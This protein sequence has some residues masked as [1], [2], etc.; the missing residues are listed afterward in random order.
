MKVFLRLAAV[1]TALL[2][3]G[4]SIYLDDHWNYSTQLT[5]ASFDDFIQSNLAQQKTVFVRWIASPG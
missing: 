3:L 1:L 4:A 5:E 2:P